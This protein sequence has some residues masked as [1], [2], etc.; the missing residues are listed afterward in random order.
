MPE[1]SGSGGLRA[2][3]AFRVLRQSRRP[4]SPSPDGA[5]VLTPRPQRQ[6]RRNLL[7]N[8]ARHAVF[9]RWV[10]L[11]S[12]RSSISRR[13]VEPRVRWPGGR[14]QQ[15][16]RAARLA[17]AAPAGVAAVDNAQQRSSSRWRPPSVRVSSSQR[18]LTG[19]DLQR[20]AARLATS[21]APSG[22]RAPGCAFAR[23]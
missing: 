10:R 15:V 3:R 5:E 8:P 13:G 12:D 2:D 11:P 22:A 9:L 17:D 21:V 23:H 4:P 6:P 20:R 19:V 16:R 1:V 7:Q 14:R 18:R